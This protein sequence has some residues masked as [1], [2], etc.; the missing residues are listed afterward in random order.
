MCSDNNKNINNTDKK[1]L[2]SKLATAYVVNSS[3]TIFIK[4]DPNWKNI[5]N[6]LKVV[7]VCVRVMK[8][9]IRALSKDQPLYYLSVFLYF[10]TT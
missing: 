4:Q 2:T 9:K 6:T 3:Q 1:A 7:V 8:M 5:G 10:E